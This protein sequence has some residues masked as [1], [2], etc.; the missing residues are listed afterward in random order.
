LPG[1]T[2]FRGW[3][4]LLSDRRV[5][6]VLLATPPA[7]HAE[8]G[9]E[10][11][12][13]GKHVVIETPMC[14][15]V[16]EADSLIA[17]S[18]RTGRI[19]TVAHTRRWDD[20]FRTAVH[21]LASGELGRPLAFK[22]VNWHYNP[23]SLQRPRVGVAGAVEPGAADGLPSLHWRDHA[24]TGGGVLWEF[25][26]HCFDQLLQLAGRPAQTVFARIFPSPAG[27]PA[28]DGFL[29]VVSFADNLTA[30]VEVH[31]AAPASCSAGWTILGSR[32]SYSDFTQYTPTP[33]GE[34][35]DVPLSPIA[36]EADEFYGHVVRQIRTGAPNVVP[37][38]EARA[39]VALIE[40]VR[41]SARSGQTVAL[42]AP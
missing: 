13:A 7:L 25:G 2:I 38:E 31:R 8:K 41:E 39:V 1:A 40:A 9:I 34:V 12:A 3:K 16:F 30:H 27:E 24:L 42:K 23:R 33:D 35:V 5:E 26:T 21:V 36:A 18:R 11:M 20:D 29:A 4:E 37:P 17:G 10:A 22:L 19:I 32:G 15:S 6:A 14:L 28:D